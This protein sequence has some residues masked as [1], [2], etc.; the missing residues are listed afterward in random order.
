MDFLTGFACGVVYL[1]FGIFVCLV[2]CNRV[3]FFD[4]WMNRG[5]LW[6][7]ITL[8]VWPAAMITVI[9]RAW[10]NEEFEAPFWDEL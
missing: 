2:L 1:F 3:N 10:W 8:V 7:I 4:A 6:P 9:L 5:Y